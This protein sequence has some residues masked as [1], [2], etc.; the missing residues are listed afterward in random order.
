MKIDRLSFENKDTNW[1]LEP[2][3]FDP[4]TLLVG[5][6][7]VGKT[8]I[9]KCILNLKNIARGK[10]VNGAKWLVEFSTRSGVS[11]KWGGEFENRGFMS[12]SMF[13]SISNDKDDKDEPKIE[14]EELYKNDQVLINR[15]STNIFLNGV[16]TVKL[17]QTESVLSL[18]KEE[19]DIKDIYTEFEKII[20]DD[21]SASASSIHFALDDEVEEKAKKYK[22]LDQI[23]RS[24][25]NTKLKLYF[26]YI[27]QR[28]E[29]DDIAESFMDVFPHVESVKIEP[30][31]TSDKKLPFF[32][33]DVPFI[34]IKEKDVK[35]WI[36]ETKISSGMLR[37]LM[38]IAELHLCADSSII[39]ID[40][41]ENSLG[42]NCIDELT[43][44]ILS[45]G[46]DLQFV[47]TSHH[48]YIINHIDHSKWKIVSRKAGVV[49][50]YDSSEFDFDKSK[51]KAFTQLINLD[52]YNNG[53]DA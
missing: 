15:D 30:L 5:A 53:A 34:Q 24:S 10:S 7:G 29:F 43:N 45:A 16:K 38:H 50:A 31:I 28:S 22:S 46:R 18:L 17:S 27:N 3:E 39:L 20:F 14:R 21:N 49:V 52:L 32:F 41:F 8:R 26:S 35:D 44:N 40:E 47:I 1:I 23:R 33:R 13:A 48:P 51:H 25:E 36:D 37:T 12:D 11:Y 19:D 4:L 6:S 42:V 2:I 9:L